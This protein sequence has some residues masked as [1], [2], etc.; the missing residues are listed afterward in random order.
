M[1]QVKAETKSFKVEYQG[2]PEEF[3]IKRLTFGE[4]NKLQDQ[5]TN[6]KLVGGTPQANYSQALLKELSIHMCLVKSPF[7]N[8]LEVI[9]NLEPSLGEFLWVEIDN[10]NKLSEVKKLS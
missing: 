7:A 10:F 1:S 5:C 9:R 2:K 4:R 3:I 8:D 6:L